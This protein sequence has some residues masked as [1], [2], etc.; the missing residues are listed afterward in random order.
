MLQQCVHRTLRQP[1]NSYVIKI[2]ARSGLQLRLRNCDV[3]ISRF[4]SNATDATKLN[5]AAPK[6]VVP[7]EEP[8][9]EQLRLVTMQA[10]IPF[11]GFGIMDNA[12]LILAGDAIDSSLCVVLSLSTMCAAAIGN[13]IS[14]VAGIALGT[15][16]EDITT[17]LKL[18]VATLTHAQRQ[19][20][21]VRLANQFGNAI[22]ITIGCIIGMFPLL[23]IDSKAIERRKRMEEVEALFRDVVYEAKSLI[24][25][26][27]TCMFLVV[28]EEVRPPWNLDSDNKQLDYLSKSKR[29]QLVDWNELHAPKPQMRPKELVAKYVDS[30]VYEHDKLTP[31]TIPYGSGVCSLAAGRKKPVIAK[32]GDDDMKHLYMDSLKV[33]N[34]QVNSIVCVPVFSK[35]RKVIA[36]LEGINKRGGEG[37]SENDVNVLQALASHVSVALQSLTAV[38]E[39]DAKVRLKDMIQI[40]KAHA[41]K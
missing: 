27:S 19:L 14:D 17:Q 6:I 35:D 25:A 39:E 8:A 26:D 16:I 2:K 33:K 37:F 40:L 28:E 29:D 41:D 11:I 10:T 15:V 31:I 36:V 7:A 23:W 1:F 22:G 5:R 18:P 9:R 34:E 3:G 30:G 4:S 21:S 13:I 38:D 32:I 20:R 12:L 24:G